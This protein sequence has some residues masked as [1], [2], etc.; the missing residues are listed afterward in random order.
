MDGAD[1]MVDGNALGG[2]LGEIFAHEMTSARVACAGC[3]AVEPIGAQHAYMQAPGVVLRCSH[4]DAALVV[5][6]QRDGKH[7]LGFERLRWLEIS[8]R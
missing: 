2:V 4:C 1:L 5:M 3:G 7:L 8:E 6:M